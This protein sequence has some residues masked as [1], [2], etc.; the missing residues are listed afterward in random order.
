MIRKARDGYRNISYFKFICVVPAYRVLTGCAGPQSA[1][2]PAGPGAAPIAQVWWVMFWGG[3]IVLAGMTALGL[4]A[5]CRRKP[6]KRGP[7]EGKIFLLGGGLVFPLAVLATL[8]FYGIRSGDALIAFPGSGET[9]QIELRAHQ[10][11]WEFRYPDGSGGYLHDANEFHLPAGQP[12]DIRISSGDVIHSFWLP[13]LGGKLDAIPGH[14]NVLRLQADRP[15][16]FYG[17]CAEFCGAQHARMLLY[18]RAHDEAGFRDYLDNLRVS[19]GEPPAPSRGQGLFNK[20]CVLCHSL[21]PRRRGD[22][23]GPNL[24]GL[25]QRKWLGA[26]TLLNNRAN[27]ARWIS[28]HQTLKPGNRMPANTLQPDEIEAVVDY[29]WRTK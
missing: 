20:Q 11:W 14:V 19:G 16:E 9:L 21:D 10:W 12:V 27:L 13:R 17:Q 26:G 5:A 25:Q 2:D 15:G 28:D 24:A 23:P 7:G 3:L 1:L 18:A 29:L 8:L 6:A 4:C 22:K